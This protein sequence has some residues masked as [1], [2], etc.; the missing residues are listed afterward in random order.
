M[1]KY[2][3]AINLVF[4]AM[5]AGT[6]SPISSAA[7][8]SSHTLPSINVHYEIHST[9][10][11]SISEDTTIFAGETVERAIFKKAY[12]VKHMEIAATEV[13][14]ETAITQDSFVH[15][16]RK[17][18]ITPAMIGN[19]LVLDVDLKQTNLIR[20]DK[21]MS[22]H[23]VSTSKLGSRIGPEYT[24]FVEAP[25]VA[26]FSDRR[27]LTFL[28]GESRKIEL[29]SNDGSQRFSLMITATYHL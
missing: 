20:I 15:G 23:E 28:S 27:Y 12:Y 1:T 21:L 6:F 24:S 25:V 26:E 2:I 9:N 13:S 8:A 4:T 16:L 22:A 18:K 10:Q 29:A 19:M 3:A 5:I 14:T 7:N 11:R 17:L